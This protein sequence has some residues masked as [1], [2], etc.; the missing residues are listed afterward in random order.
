MNW[1]T[2]ELYEGYFERDGHMWIYDGWIH[3]H[4]P[5][6][7]IASVLD[8]LLWGIDSSSLS[9][10]MRNAG[11]HSVA[12]Y[13][14][15]CPIL[16]GDVS[17]A[18][19]HVSAGYAHYD[20]GNAY[21][22]LDSLLGLYGEVRNYSSGVWQTNRF[23]DLM[24]WGP[25]VDPRDRKIEQGSD[26]WKTGMERTFYAFGMFPFWPI[27][28]RDFLPAMSLF[29]QHF[30]KKGYDICGPDDHNRYSGI[31]RHLDMKVSSR[32]SH[33]VLW[34]SNGEAMEAAVR[35]EGVFWDPD[36]V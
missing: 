27:G 9:E 32:W 28:L 3:T 12:E 1:I 16:K 17:S 36:L 6:N 34:V 11:A 35:F 8:H 33:G 4:T 22:D 26:T 7:R 15:K 5:E 20:Y 13:L 24:E 18:A 2:P 29:H 30:Q 31:E 19:V 21:E 14:T 23:D 10:K 25:W